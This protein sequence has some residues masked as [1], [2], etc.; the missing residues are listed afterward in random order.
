MNKVVNFTKLRFIFIT[1]SILTILGG[2]TG[3]VLHKGFDLGIDFNAGLNQ[4]VQIAPVGFIISYKGEGNPTVNVINNGISFELRTDAG[5]VRHHISFD[6]Y[7]TL[8]A[9]ASAVSEIPG[10]SIELKV[11][12]LTTSDKILSL[13]HPVNL[14]DES[15]T[16][17]ILPENGGISLEEVRS[18]LTAAM[19]NVQVQTVGKSE[20]QE[21]MVR[22]EDPGNDKS[23]STTA[24]NKIA[25]ALSTKFGAD[26]VLIKQSDFVG[27]KFSANLGQQSFLLTLMALGL[28]L[29]YVWIRFKLAY[30]VSAI[31]ALFHDVLIMLGFLGT[32]QM[33]I[34]TATIAAVLTII[35][36]SLNDTIVIFDRIRENT[37]LMSESKFK[38]II[39]TS[40]TQSLSRTLITSLTTLLAALSLYIFGTGSIKDFA[41]ALIIGVVVGTYSSIFIASPI[42][43][44]WTNIRNA[45][46]KK[47][48]A[49]KFGSRK[50]IKDETA[51]ADA[52]PKKAEI[53]QVERKLKGKRQKKK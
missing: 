50:E 44:G 39:D 18:V 8:R 13:N 38:D 22:V 49:L 7:T 10:L 20:H 14:G 43:L 27:P 23:F 15:A 24:A 45:R 11:E 47:K 48:E 34:S 25:A 5:V 29:V 53:P 4:R 9:V 1:I 41:L 16:V 42:L 35:G 33:E 36:Y 46:K 19:G 3:T 26:Q 12:G 32:F 31:S 28:I 51:E 52:V 2:I 17:N 6:E 37:S 30:A 21:F 40:I